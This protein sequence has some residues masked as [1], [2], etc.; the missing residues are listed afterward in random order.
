MT[1]EAKV[2]AI[3][4]GIANGQSIVKFVV[5][6]LGDL[7]VTLERLARIDGKPLSIP[8]FV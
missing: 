7:H 1:G 2:V 3:R 4:L 8:R 5:V 6:G